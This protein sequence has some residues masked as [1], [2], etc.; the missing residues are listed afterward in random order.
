M[1]AATILDDYITKFSRWG[2]WGLAGDQLGAMNCVG[3]EQVRR[4]PRWSAHAVAAAQPRADSDRAVASRNQRAQ[5]SNR[6][7]K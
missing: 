3:H 4:L 1:T 7:S 2:I 5:R 6:V